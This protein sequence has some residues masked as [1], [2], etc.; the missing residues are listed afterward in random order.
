MSQLPPRADVVII[1]SGH[2]GLVSAILLAR[3]AA[4]GRGGPAGPAEPLPVAETAE[5]Y[6]RPALRQ[7]FI[8]L[9]RGSV[10]D[11]L[12]RFEFR[13]ELLVAMYAVTDGL[14]GLTAGPDDPGTGNNFLAH[15]MCRLPGSDG[16]WMFAAAG[17]GTVSRPFASP[18]PA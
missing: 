8:D 11:Y 7:V 10:A 15:N 14:S 5:R 2:N 3:A 6:V 12:A 9:V 13:S 4:V 16:T 1:G 18:A 17:M